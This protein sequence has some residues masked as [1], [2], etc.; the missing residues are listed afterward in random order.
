M[1]STRLFQAKDSADDGAWPELLDLGQSYGTLHQT[2]IS[3]DGRYLLAVLPVGDATAPDQS[4][5]TVDL[6]EKKIVNT[7]VN[8]DQNMPILAAIPC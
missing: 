5:V 1:I 8:K 2:T 6:V 7:L 3:S 4:L